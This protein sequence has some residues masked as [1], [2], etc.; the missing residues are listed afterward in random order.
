M[1]DRELML[2]KISELQFAA[3]DLNLYLDTH[4]KCKKALALYKKYFLAAKQL[5]AEYERRYGPLVGA[6]VNDNTETWKWVND[7]W[8]WDVSMGGMR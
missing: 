8:P 7:P 5:I 4:P 2:K 6:S 1:S 3:L